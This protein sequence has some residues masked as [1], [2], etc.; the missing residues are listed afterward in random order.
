VRG[1]TG[2]VLGAGAQVGDGDL[3]VGQRLG[4]VAGS[5]AVEQEDQ[6]A[7]RAALGEFGARTGDRP[8]RQGDHQRQ[9]AGVHIRAHVAVGLGATDEPFEDLQQDLA[10]PAVL[11]ILL[12]LGPRA[13]EPDRQLG[14]DGRRSWAIGALD[15]FAATLSERF[16][17]PLDDLGP[18]GVGRL[19]EKASA[20]NDLWRTR[21]QISG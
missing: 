14:A 12:K 18:D 15:E 20:Q 7:S 17:A 10:Q 3:A 4:I 5:Q 8:Q 19:W 16:L 9:I 13:G 6:T 2:Q 1:L 21:G 11:G